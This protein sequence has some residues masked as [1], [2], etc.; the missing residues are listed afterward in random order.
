VT[1]NQTGAVA[2]ALAEL[3]EQREPKLIVSEMPK[4]LRTKKVFIDWSQNS[5]S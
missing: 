4:R 3:L 1:Y 2:K 5:E